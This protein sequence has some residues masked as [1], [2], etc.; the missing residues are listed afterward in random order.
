MVWACR[1]D[2][3]LPTLLG[4]C[5]NSRVTINTRKK[6][7]RRRGRRKRGKGKREK[8][9]EEEAKREMNLN[10]FDDLVLEDRHAFILVCDLLVGLFK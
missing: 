8:G 6:E 9:G 3:H 5:S 2:S 10:T 4:P 1:F 7:R